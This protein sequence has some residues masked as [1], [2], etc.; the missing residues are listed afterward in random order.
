MT[1]VIKTSWILSVTVAISSC[2]SFHTPLSREISASSSFDPYN[3]IQLRDA[4]STANPTPAGS[5][6]QQGFDWPVDRARMTRGFLP[7]KRRPHLGLD[8]AAPKGTAIMA[9]TGGRVIYAGQGFSGYG[10]MILIES[11]GKWAHLYAHFN[12]ILVSEGQY[13]R[14]GEVIG[15]MGR[16]GRATGV[17][18]HFEIR[19]NK[20]PIDPLPVLPKIAS[21]ASH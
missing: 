13:V 12:R 5:S 2:A 20:T 8:L 9:S 3:N 11:G 14:Q 15:E 7:N 21:L 16:T 1:N 10:K 6:V 17:H 4:A 18:L 19:Q